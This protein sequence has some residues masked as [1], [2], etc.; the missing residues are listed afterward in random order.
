MTRNW[1]IRKF[2]RFQ[3]SCLCFRLGCDM[4]LPRQ[5]PRVKL[6]KMVLVMLSTK[7]F[8]GLNTVYSVFTICAN[9]LWANKHSD[10]F[11]VFVLNFKYFVCIIF[12]C[13]HL[14]AVAMLGQG[15]WPH[16]KSKRST[17]SFKFSSFISFSSPMYP[18]QL[19]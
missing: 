3:I 7:W 19:T 9:S 6:L 17:F 8:I 1:E 11:S 5:I 2:N 12:L 4:C 10:S 16:L 18:F 14:V 13:P 15:C